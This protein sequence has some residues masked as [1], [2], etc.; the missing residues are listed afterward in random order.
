[1]MLFFDF[2]YVKIVKLKKFKPNV[3]G[4]LASSG[5][6]LHHDFLYMIMY[7]QDSNYNSDLEQ[8]LW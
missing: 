1:M 3:F 4:C 8:K 7:S 2:L 6:S 5:F